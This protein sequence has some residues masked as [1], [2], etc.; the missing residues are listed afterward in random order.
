MEGETFSDLWRDDFLLATGK[1]ACHSLHHLDLE[2]YSRSVLKRGLEARSRATD[3]E[4]NKVLDR[5][6]EYTGVLPLF[7]CLSDTGNMAYKTSLNSSELLQL[8]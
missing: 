7:L 4:N 8:S 1:V 3:G 5:A 6:I 2:P